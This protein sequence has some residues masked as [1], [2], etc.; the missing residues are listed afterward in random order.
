MLNNSDTNTEKEEKGGKRKGYNGKIIIFSIYPLLILL[1]SFAGYTIK[2]NDSISINVYKT[3]FIEVCK[4][5][6]LSE[7][8]KINILSAEDLS[9]RLKDTVYTTLDCWLELRIDQQML[10]QRWRNGKVNVYPVSTGNKYLSR[11]VESRPG[12]FAIN[13]K[14][15]HHLSSQYNNADMYHFMTFNQGIGFHSLNGTGYYYALG[16]MPSSHGC[17]R[18][19]HEDAAKLFK[20]CPIGT[21][22]LAHNG[23][24]A[25]TVG[26][27]PKDFEYEQKPTKEEFKLMLAKNL[28]NILNGN[29]YTRERYYVV[30]DPS[31]IP[32]SGIYISY[33]K[34]I[35]EIQK[36]P[37]TTYR[38]SS[39]YID[40]LKINL[41][42]EELIYQDNEEYLEIVGE[43]LD[44]ES[45]ESSSDEEEYSD[46]ELV[47][48]YFRNPIGILPYFP[49]N[50]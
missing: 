34:K 7:R 42:I 11:S 16:K 47:K 48:K 18:M 12:L 43:L 39:T 10:Y 41:E 19:R 20:E 28:Y 32:T 6:F 46:E 13:Y 2:T 40:R 31:V 17:I 38:I 8:Y 23:Y 14:N 22:V 44:E 9:T 4:D 1:L 37:K 29:Y 35:P 45:Q 5:S 30:I 26:F 33:D 50:Q 3:N 24:T 25:R 36:L 21:L 15:P 27:A 49:P